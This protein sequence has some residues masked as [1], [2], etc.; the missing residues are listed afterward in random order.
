[1]RLLWLVRVVAR[2][3]IPDQGESRLGPRKEQGKQHARAPESN[4]RKVEERGRRRSEGE[5]RGGHRDQADSE[6]GSIQAGEWNTDPQASLQQ[7]SGCGASTRWSSWSLLASSGLGISSSAEPRPVSHWLHSPRGNRATGAGG[8]CKGLRPGQGCLA[9]QLGCL[10]G[11]P[12]VQPAF[13]LRL[14]TC[15][16]CPQTIFPSL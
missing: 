8:R 11:S 16:L 10:G 1:M 15:L 9:L 12:E 14:I 13:I 6:A 4:R 3:W 7:L 5:S 2:A